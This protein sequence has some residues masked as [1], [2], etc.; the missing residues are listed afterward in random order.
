MHLMTALTRHPVLLPVL[1]RLIVL[2]A[3]YSSTA[4]GLYLLP[5]E[6]H[7]IIRVIAQSFLL[8]T[9]WYA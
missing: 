8:P 1:M 2:V 6:Q 9:L 5:C 3:D 7:K 4:T